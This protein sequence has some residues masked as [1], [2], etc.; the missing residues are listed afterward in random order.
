MRTK[1]PTAETVGSFAFLFACAQP[2]NYYQ[3]QQQIHIVG[4]VGA[5]GPI[6]WAETVIV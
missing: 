2:V 3:N 6:N 1:L 5:I 4:Y